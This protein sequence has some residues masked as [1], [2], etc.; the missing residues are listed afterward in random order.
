MSD[1]TQQP[2][3]YKVSDFVQAL[4]VTYRALNADKTPNTRPYSIRLSGA[5]SLSMNR[6]HAEK[7]ALD[8]ITALYDAGDLS[9]DAA[10]TLSYLTGAVLADKE[11]VLV[12]DPA[13]INDGW[14]DPFAPIG[15]I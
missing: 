14:A 5:D 4:T 11:A 1:I 8:L 6:E 3:H 10:G 9:M 7:L 15:E 2:F 13:V 12:I